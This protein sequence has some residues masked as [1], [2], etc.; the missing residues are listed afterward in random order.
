MKRSM[1]VPGHDMKKIKASPQE[2]DELGFNPKAT[3]SEWF[4]DLVS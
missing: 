2:Y 1:W 3:V 4:H